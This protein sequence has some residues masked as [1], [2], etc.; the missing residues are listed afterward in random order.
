M[1]KPVCVASKSPAA[2]KSKMP[3][4]L[5]ALS[6]APKTYPATEYPAPGVKSIFYEGAPI[7]GRPTLT[8]AYYGVPSHKPGE[9]VPGMVLV[10]GGGGTA[11]DQWV[12]MWNERGYAAISMDW[13]GTIPVGEFP[14]RK[15][16]DSHGP[17]PY[18]VDQIDL[19]QN[20]Q[21]N[22][23][24]IANVILANSFLRALPDVD[25]ERIG[26]TGISWGGY[27]TCIVSGVD[28]RFA[29]AAP[30]YGNGYIHEDSFM[31][32]AIKALGPDRAG[33]WAEWWDPSVY[34]AKAK[35]PVL[36]VNGTND[37]AF[38]MNSHQRSTHLIQG[39]STRVIRVRMDHSHEAGWEPKE[40][41]AFADAILKKEMPLTEVKK[42]GRSGDA[43]W[44]TFKAIEPVTKAELN[45]TRSN[46]PAWTKREW[47]IAPAQIDIGKS[48]AFAA[49]PRDATA[50]YFN[51]YDDRGLLVSTE[52]VD[53][54]WP[55]R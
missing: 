31:S 38:F 4:S 9:K 22:Y 35:C 13:T 11:F 21:W 14:N 20:E 36:W 10:H 19:P 40:T 45:Y 33:R 29:F 46:D 24:A 8:F 53:I 17:E 7:A 15:K 25:P 30:V 2:S 49:V 16:T 54:F 39:K 28:T 52:Y 37:F 50:Y 51:I 48:R 47:I 26:V 18:G 3:W 6:K 34:L 23:Y 44:V 1:T 42:M 43:A 55:M 41:F 12:R 5:K 27:L 32:D